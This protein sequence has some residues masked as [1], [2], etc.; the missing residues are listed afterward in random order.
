MA[1]LDASSRTDVVALKS[2]A[3]D[4]QPLRMCIAAVRLEDGE[5]RLI[6]EAPAEVRLLPEQ[7]LHV[8]VRYSFREA[9]KKREEFHVTLRSRLADQG[10]R[11][12][13]RDAADKRLVNDSEWGVVEQEFDGLEPGEHDLVLDVCA[14]YGVRAWRGPGEERRQETEFAITIPVHVDTP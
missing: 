6:N 2:T 7:P 8:Q 14:S 1:T 10:P 4:L 9:S 12:Q 5:V 11:E 13:H 3:S